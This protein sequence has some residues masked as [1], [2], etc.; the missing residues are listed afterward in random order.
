MDRTMSRS[1]IVLTQIVLTTMGFHRPPGERQD[2]SPPIHRRIHFANSFTKTMS[3][4]SVT[5]SS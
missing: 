5:I 4:N 1:L 2:V 3:P